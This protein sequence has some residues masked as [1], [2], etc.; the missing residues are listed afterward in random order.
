MLLK[1]TGAMQKKQTAQ[2]DAAEETVDELAAVAGID[3][4]PENPLPASQ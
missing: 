1:A 3:L 2:L 4:E